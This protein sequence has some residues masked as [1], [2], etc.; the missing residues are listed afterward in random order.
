MNLDIKI[1][2]LRE[3]NLLFGGGET[4]VEP[5]R[6]MAKAGAADSAAP[7][8]IRIGLVGPSQEVQLAGRWLPRLNNVA[9]A[10]EKSARAGTHQDTAKGSGSGRCAFGRSRVASRHAERCAMWRSN[11]G[12]NEKGFAD[13]GE[14]GAGSREL[15]ADAQAQQVR[16]H[17]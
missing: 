5:R 3:P 7:K 17:L 15:L 6:I 11:L 13:V 2:C 16:R 9:I 4:G 12:D 10:R 14:R 8:E 1:E